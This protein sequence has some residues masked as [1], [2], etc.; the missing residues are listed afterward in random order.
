MRKHLYSFI[1]SLLMLCLSSCYFV[2]LVN[3]EAV[4]EIVKYNEL[5]VILSKANFYEGEIVN[6]S[7][8]TVN[9]IDNE[10]GEKQKTDSFKI[11]WDSDKQY[12]ENGKPITKT[13]GEYKWQ[14][15]VEGCGQYITP[16]NVYKSSLENLIIASFPKQTIYFDDDK[17]NKFN[18]L[19]MQLKRDVKY[20]TN[21]GATQHTY[22]DVSISECDIYYYD[23]NN[24]NNRV[25]LEIGRPLTFQD[26]GSS[27]IDIVLST[28]GITSK[29]KITCT[30]PIFL[31]DKNST[32]NGPVSYLDRFVP[33]VYDTEDDVLL[34]INNT[35]IDSERRESEYNYIKPEDVDVSYGMNYY[36]NHNYKKEIRTPSTGDVPILVIPV[37]YTFYPSLYNSSIHETIEKCF[38]GSDAELYFESL[39]SF[40]YKSSFGKL[41]FTGKV[42]PA[43]FPQSTN[44]SEFQN[45]SKNEQT[46]SIN[47]SYGQV[48]TIVK[49]AILFLKSIGFDMRDYDS[50]G[51]GF[52]DAVWIINCSPIDQKSVY[53]G[54]AYTSNIDNAEPNYTDPSPAIFSLCPVGLLN[55]D[56]SE[57]VGL[58]KGG[59]ND[60]GD[61]HTLIHEAGHLLGLE[62]Y[63]STKKDIPYTI[64]DG[65]NNNKEKT[66]YYAPMGGL[67]IMDQNYLDHN[68]YSKIMLG[69][70]KPYIVYGRSAISLKASLYE[71]QCIVIPYDDVDYSD[72]KYRNSE[73]KV[74]FNPYDEYLVIEYNI[75]DSKY[76]ID[77]FDNDN[78]LAKGYDIFR[79]IP[80]NKNGIRV[81]YVNRKSLVYNEETKEFEAINDFKDVINNNKILYSPVTNTDVGNN[82]ESSILSKTDYEKFNYDDYDN[83]VMILPANSKYYV[84]NSTARYEQDM[85]Y[86][87]FDDETYKMFR[88]FNYYSNKTKITGSQ[89]FN[90]KEPRLSFSL[91]DSYETIK[92]GSLTYSEI[93]YLYYSLIEQDSTFY[94]NFQYNFIREYLYGDRDIGIIENYDCPDEFNSVKKDGRKFSYLFHI[95]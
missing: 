70:T 22:C 67:D 77:S 45:L 5:E 15:E 1:I 94:Q 95:S 10:T 43:F 33:D 13:E 7:D 78:L 59:A 8:M 75:I 80:F 71:N 11:R 27:K 86:V 91:F 23:K 50:D 49:E 53:G 60:N 29:N 84:N 64:Q 41:N 85:S 14:F 48:L 69:W 87:L 39:R 40:Y 76:E 18:L 34:E 36:K 3:N 51:D 4:D 66:I 26:S 17:N 65:T 68:S 46:N 63:Y 38:F 44:V 79:T 88:P 19:G 72:P 31:V 74:I 62:D 89:N 56:Y 42:A 47:L 82:C 81:F 92:L 21:R 24:N 54:W 12:V 28:N 58:S 30:F 2:Y 55:S 6:Y 32:S 35:S 20:V 57:Y 37:C 93:E 73:G 61:A 16:V 83:E 9:I 25:N 52:I 90:G